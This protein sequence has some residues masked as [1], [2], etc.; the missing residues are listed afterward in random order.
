MRFG[1]FLVT[2]VG[3]GLAAG[4]VF[5]AKDYL[6]DPTGAAT[7]SPATPQTVNIVIAKRDIEF[8]QPVGP[9][10]LTVQQWPAEA[11]PRGAFTSISALVGDDA[12]Q[13]KRALVRLYEG[14]VIL[15]SKLSEPG[16]RVT[17]VQ[18]LGENTRAMAIKVDAV[19]AVGGFVTP[20]DY[21]D[22][23]LT[24]TSGD[25]MR[26][27]TILQNIRVIGVD[28]QSEESADQPVVARTV[29]VEV[30][31]DQGQRL[32]LAQRAGTLSLTLRTLNE[33]Q[34]TALDLVELSD[35]FAA[36]EPEVE[37]DVQAEV[38]A[39]VSPR[40]PSITVRRGTETQTVQLR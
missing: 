39:P 18:K 7:A 16:E 9:Q 10:A 37:V 22:I 35:L 31:P 29:T 38:E 13:N 11:V 32:A 28:Q 6:G 17:I 4:A 36:P 19:T 34:D 20:G 25:S 30:S 1:S 33:V 3:V 5:L 21:V 14:E 26:A 24:Q 23:L 12:T 15:A 2:L 27:G 40:K 8:G